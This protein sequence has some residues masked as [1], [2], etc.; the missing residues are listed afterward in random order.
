MRDRR[1]HGFVEDEEEDGRRE[2]K[3]GP[4][5]SALVSMIGLY[6]IVDQEDNGGGGGRDS[7]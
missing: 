5:R 4:G 6:Q 1:F 7:I 3:G 2:E